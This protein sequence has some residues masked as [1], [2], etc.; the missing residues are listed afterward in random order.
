LALWINQVWDPQSTVKRRNINI[1]M[2][3][4]AGETMQSWTLIGEIPIGWKS[5]QFKTKSKK[6]GIEEL[7][8]QCEGV[9]V[10]LG[11]GGGMTQPKGRDSLGY[12]GSSGIEQANAGPVGNANAPQA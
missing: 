11:G 4:A 6:V 10:I 5:P 2:F 9:K 3:N 7:E 8:V 12:F 1:L